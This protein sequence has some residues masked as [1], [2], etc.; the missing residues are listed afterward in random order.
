MSYFDEHQEIALFPLKSVLFPGGRLTLKIFEQRYLELVSD[1]LKNEKGFGVCLLQQGAEILQA[2]LQQTVHRV[3]TYASIVDWDQLENGLLGI[4]VEGRNKFKV[5][6]CW[7]A[8]NGLLMSDVVFSRE[9]WFGK[10]VIRTEEKFQ[11]L[12][13]LLQSLEKHPM[14]DQMNLSIDY[15]NLWELGWRLGEL[16]PIANASRQQLLELNDPWQRIRAIEN[17]LLELSV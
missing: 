1:C 2:G 12:T 17:A 10:S 16:V 9:D 3:G 6:R 7:A 11:E 4:T 14:V 8:E 15:N 5:G 13:E